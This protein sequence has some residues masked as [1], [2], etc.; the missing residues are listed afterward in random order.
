MTARRQR[1]FRADVSLVS[2]VLGELLSARSG[3]GTPV[4]YDELPITQGAVMLIADAIASMDLVAVDA[5]RNGAPVAGEFAVLRQ[6]NPEED[7][8]DTLHKIVQSLFWSGN[9]YGLVPFERRASGEVEAITILN[10]D[11][12]GVQ[13]DPMNDL[14]VAWWSIHGQRADRHRVNHWKMNDDPRKGP[15]GRSPLKLCATALETYGWAY[16]YL[17]DFFAGGGNPGSVLNT[18]IELD[19]AKI[20]EVANEWVAARKQARPAIL[21]KWITFDVPPTSGEL[22]ETVKVLE[23]ATSEVARM[24][25]IPVSLVNAPVAGYS[26]QY[27][28]VGDE[29]RR[30]L[31]VSL[32][33]TWIA[34]IE[35]GFSALLP[36]GVYAKLDP[37]NL[38]RADLFPETGP[39]G[40]LTIG[41][42]AMMPDAATPTPK[43]LTA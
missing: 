10:P 7:R 29:F 36:E 24:L 38:F 8:A 25:N 12:V 42:P 5:P 15:L 28:N 41:Q 40:S 4:P 39:A 6:P 22:A 9:A 33:T 13:T 11:S 14:R 31:A 1:K 32:G 34:R 21:P 26:L 3:T 37:S 19:P 35:R 20:E 16:R 43:E 18:S 2:Q 30:W 27:S 23:F 17:G